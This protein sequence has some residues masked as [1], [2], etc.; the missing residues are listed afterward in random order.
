M[1]ALALAWHH[2]DTGRPE[3][4]LE[5]LEGL[6]GDAALSAEALLLRGRA[7]LA[8]DRDA[9]AHHVA[10]RALAVDADSPLLWSLLA[11]ACLALEDLPGAERAVLTALR[12]D[13]TD[14]GLMADY[15]RILARAGQDEKAQRVLERAGE[16][17]PQSPQVAHARTYLALAR[18][19]DRTALHEAR[20]A[21]ADD[22]GSVAAQS[23]LGATSLLRGDARTGLSASRRAASGR[24]GDPALAELARE[25]RLQAH[26]V[27]L[28]MRLIT[29]FGQVQ[30][31]LAGL[32]LVFGANAFLPPPAVAGVVLAWL[33]FCVYT[34]TA[35]PL[36]RAWARWRW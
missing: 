10:G 18:G 22:P 25:A 5:A 2:L 20:R 27:M 15:A 35:D 7:L 9:E 11:D 34:W 16:L 31:W 4:A 6:S 28:G 24:I 21:L 19:D 3:R 23:M 8:L 30:V 29:R 26:P 32:L 12:L 14:A 1:N 17:D 36:L 13:P 33:A